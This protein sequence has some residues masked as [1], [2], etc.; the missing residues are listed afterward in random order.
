MPFHIFLKGCHDY[1][2]ICTLKE[3]QEKY[4]QDAK[5]EIDEKFKEVIK[6]EKAYDNC[7]V[8]QMSMLQKP[9]QL[10]IICAVDQM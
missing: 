4:Y 7:L 1:Q 8:L 3:T 5:F 6:D 9:G 2:S 10:N